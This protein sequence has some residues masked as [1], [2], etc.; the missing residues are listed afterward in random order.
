[1]V[2]V[3]IKQLSYISCMF[4]YVP[5]TMKSWGSCCPI[6]CQ[7]LPTG[8]GCCH[9]HYIVHDSRHLGNTEIDIIFKESLLIN[10]EA[11]LLI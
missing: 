3:T 2:Q 4:G 7:R 6:Y 11:A 10:N 9:C 5:V 1:M 8:A